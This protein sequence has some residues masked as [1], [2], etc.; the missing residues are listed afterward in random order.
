MS[1]AATKMSAMTL[2]ISKS[3]RASVAYLYDT[4]E[5]RKRNGSSIV[6]LRGASWVLVTRSCM[7][8]LGPFAA[9]S[10]AARRIL[11]IQYQELGAAALRTGLT[12]RE[13]HRAACHS[14]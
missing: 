5:D 3:P 8:A 14:P 2:R 11:R 13:Q 9:R 6:D 7:S 4:D 1:A 10:D 12:T